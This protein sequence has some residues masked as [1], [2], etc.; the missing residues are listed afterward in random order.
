MGGGPGYYGGDGT[1]RY[2]FGEISDV[3]TAIGTYEGEMDGALNELY[4][5]FKQLFAQDWQGAA[6]E[7]CDQAQ[8]KWNQGATEIKTALGQV[9]QKL[10][11]S[12]EQMQATDKRI[13]AGM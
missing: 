8:Q 7:A 1:I 3:A 10:G 9:G 2:N 13:A 5:E 6:G 12:A 4:R 11:A